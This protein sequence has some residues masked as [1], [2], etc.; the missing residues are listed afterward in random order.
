[1]QYL[2]RKYSFK[3]VMNVYRNGSVIY[4]RLN[5]DLC[6]L[7]LEKVI[8]LIIRYIINIKVKLTVVKQK[9]VNLRVKLY[10]FHIISIKVNNRSRKVRF[11]LSCGN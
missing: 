2:P 10:C 11:G 7:A 9:Q 4:F 6:K 5:K 3:K 8:Y 1:M